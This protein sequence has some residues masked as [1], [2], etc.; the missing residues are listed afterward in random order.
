MHLT[1]PEPPGSCGTRHKPHSSPKRY[2]CFSTRSFPNCFLPFSGKSFQEVAGIQLFSFSAKVSDLL[3][4]PRQNVVWKR[5]RWMSEWACGL[6]ITP[7]PK[8]TQRIGTDFSNWQH[9]ATAR[10]A[11][12]SA[13][14]QPLVCFLDLWP[15]IC[16]GPQGCAHSIPF[17]IFFT[18]TLHRLVWETVIAPWS[19]REPL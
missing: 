2:V 4:V 17:S 15:A 8:H 18:A 13:L 14:L 11:S 5:G 3:H 6:L 7:P 16:S 9:W 1:S 12:P 19:L 10:S